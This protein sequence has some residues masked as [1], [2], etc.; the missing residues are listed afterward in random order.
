MSTKPVFVDFQ[1][2]ICSA[3]LNPVADAVWDALGE[4]KTP[5]EARTNI[6]AI[7]E[8]PNDGSPYV[9]KNLAWLTASAA[10][11][12]NELGGRDAADAHP[13]SAITGLETRLTNIETKNAQQD[14][15]F[16]NN[17]AVQDARDDGQDALIA[18]KISDA[19]SDGSLYGRKNAA[20]TVVP[21]VITVHNTLTGRNATDAHPQAAITGLETRL[22]NIETKNTSQDTAI[23]G[24]VGEAPNDGNEYVRKNLAWAVSS[25]QAPT[26]RG[27]HFIN[28]DM[29][30]WQRG[31]SFALLPGVS[32]YTADR[33][34]CFSSIAATV[35]RTFIGAGGASIAATGLVDALQVPSPPAGQYFSMLQPI[36]DVRRFDGRKVVLSFYANRSIANGAKAFVR[37][38]FGTGGSGAPADATYQL[39]EVAVPG[40]THFRYYAAITLPTL[41]G[42]ISTSPETTSLNIGMEFTAPAGGYGGNVNLYGF[43]LE[44]GVTLTD[45]ERRP[46][47]EELALCQRYYH[48]MQ[49]AGLSGM[50][51][52]GASNAVI[53]ATLPVRMRVPPAWASPTVS[54][55]AISNT[56][57]ALPVTSIANLA[58]S[59]DTVRYTITAAGLV[60]GEATVH[61]DFIIRYTAEF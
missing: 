41:S 12:H 54:G 40:T 60:A 24:K 43:K 38:N 45:F 15:L 9:R 10:L 34:A 42:T 25:S 37:Y 51:F 52:G 50:A 20:W 26:P 58:S 47:A 19:P 59:V 32:Q 27:N 39:T 35:V 22:T 28:G 48:S 14:T 55:S 6:G 30:F 17:L 13:Q 61:Y 33:W 16:N 8:A 4:P 7:E 3:F 57:A 11:L 31:V 29:G 5:N 1:T 53:T 56:G 46:I 23:A 49:G 36:E 18:T 21:D 2:K 44:D